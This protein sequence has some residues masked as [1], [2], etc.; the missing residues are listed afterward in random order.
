MAKKQP[1]QPLSINRRVRPLVDALAAHAAALRIGITRSAAGALI[2]D[3]GI[4]SP[5]GLEAGRRVA[6][7]CL[8][9]LG[10]VTLGPGP[11]TSA[12]AVSV[13]TSAPVVACLGSQYA[14]WSLQEEK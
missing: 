11:E 14:G 4:A 9:G 7:I 1:V 3:A 10:V 6:E 5:G 12:I 13:H 8:G 2:I